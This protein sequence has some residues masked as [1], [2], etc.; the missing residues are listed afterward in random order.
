MVGDLSSVPTRE[1]CLYLAV[2]LD[3]ATRRVVGWA[4][5][6]TFDTAL[7]LTALRRALADRRPAAGLLAHPD[8]GS[9]YASRAYRVALAAHGAAPSMSRKGDC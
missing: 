3:L 2:L 7:P 1:G 9:Q 8:R 5:G 6:P 4:T